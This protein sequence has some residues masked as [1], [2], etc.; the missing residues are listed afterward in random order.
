MLHYYRSVWLD[1]LVAFAAVR[2][3]LHAEVARSIPHGCYFILLLIIN[4]VQL[5]KSVS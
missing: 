3:R 1:S 2:F 5:S 4:Q